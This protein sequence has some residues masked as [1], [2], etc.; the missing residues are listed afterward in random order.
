MGLGDN[1]DT[2]CGFQTE[3]DI[4]VNQKSVGVSVT[5]TIKSSPLISKTS[6]TANE[7]DVLVSLQERISD[8]LQVPVLKSTNVCRYTP[9]AVLL[10]LLTQLT[11]LLLL[12]TTKSKISVEPVVDHKFQGF[13]EATGWFSMNTQREELSAT[14]T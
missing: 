9:M 4:N 11:P 6:P 12:N 2:L 7:Q 3:L 5:A 13:Q 14:N 8:V 1:T 10:S